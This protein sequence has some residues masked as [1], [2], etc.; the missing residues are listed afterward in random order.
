M[1]VLHCRI[2]TFPN[3]QGR[4]SA[5]ST[6]ESYC[7]SYDQRMTQLDLIVVSGNITDDGSPEGYADAR[8]LVETFAHNRGAAQVWCVSNHDTRDAFTAALATAHLDADGHDIGQPAPATTRS[9]A[10]TSQVNGLRVIILDRVNHG[11]V[12]GRIESDQLRWLHDVLANPAPAGTVLAFHYPPISV[13]TEWAATSLQEPIALADLL[14]GSDVRTVLSA[15]VHAGITGLL[16]GIPVWVT[17]GVPAGIDLTAPGGTERAVRGAAATLVELNWANS[18]MFHVLHARDCRAG[19]QLY[20]AD[21]RTWQHLGD[22]DGPTRK[23]A[24]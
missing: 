19:E 14:C 7:R 4:T 11:Q 8:A 22:E 17:P 18:Q 24:G 16:A 21:G 2:S 3:K 5:A 9:C 20:L 13:S 1:R 15:H 12:A 10:A 23:V 6:H